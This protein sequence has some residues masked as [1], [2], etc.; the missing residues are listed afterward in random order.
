M[1]V[2]FCTQIKGAGLPGGG[3]G[4]NDRTSNSTNGEHRLASNT[5]Y[6]EHGRD[7][8]DAASKNPC[9]QTE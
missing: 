5:I 1:L 3:E 7:S 6:I 9:E 8:R 2:V 4:C